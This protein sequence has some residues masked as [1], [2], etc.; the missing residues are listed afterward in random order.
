MTSR[1][2]IITPGM[3]IGPEVTLRALAAL[4]PSEVVLIGRR[5][6]LDAANAT[7]G[8]PLQATSTLAPIPGALAVIDPGDH[9]EPTEVAAIRLAAQHCLDGTAS[10]MVTGP[11]HKKQLVDRGFRFSGHTDFLGHLCGVDHEVMAFVGGQFTVAL[12]TTHIP[13]MAVGAALS[14]H[15]IR[16]VVTTLYSALVADI[17][18]L[19]PRVGVCGL[20]PHAGEGGMLGTEEIEII[21]PACDHLRAQGLPVH[22]PMSAETAFMLMARGDLDAVVAMYHDQGLVPLKAVEF[23]RSVNWTLGLPIV[24]TSV[25]HGTADGL[26]GTATADATSMAAALALARRIIANRSGRLRRS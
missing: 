11:I 4:A 15:R 1:P 9:D 2:V 7:I 19:A 17:G 10:A 14:A 21:G 24:R 20:N 8:L 26:V 16:R 22:G 3:G 6:A 5:S 12:A 25:D 13:L 18:L 23:G